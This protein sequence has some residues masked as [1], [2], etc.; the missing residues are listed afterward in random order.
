MHVAHWQVA[1][2]QVYLLILPFQRFSSGEEYRFRALIRKF[3]PSLHLEGEAEH[4][5]D[6]QRRGADADGSGAD[7]GRANS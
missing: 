4:C 6:S 2:P 3:R 1:S 7:C 5:H